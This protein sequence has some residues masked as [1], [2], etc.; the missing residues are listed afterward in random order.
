MT[1]V[2]IK[3]TKVYDAIVRA[4]DEGKE[5]I[6]LEGGTYSSKTYSALQFLIMLARTAALPRQVDIN[7]VEEETW[8]SALMH[9]TGSKWENIRLRKLAKAQ[10]M[11]LSQYGLR[12]AST[13]QLIAGHTEEEVYK[14]L[15]TPYKRPEERT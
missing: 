6:C 5:G 4:W 3:T 7:I 14:A 2:T 8:G 12:Q 9:H 10:G 1:T 11:T 13:D 15:G